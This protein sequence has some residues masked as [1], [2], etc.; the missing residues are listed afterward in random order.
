MGMTKQFY[1]FNII[2]YIKYMI[3]RHQIRTAR[4]LKGWAQSHLAKLCGLTTATIANIE[5]GK[6]NP[7][8]STLRKIETIFITHSIGFEAH[9]GVRRLET[10]IISFRGYKGFLEFMDLVDL[11]AK[12]HP[13]SEFLVAHV[14]ER[15]FM[16]WQGGGPSEKHSNAIKNANITYRILIRENDNFKP[17]TYATYAQL[18]DNAFQPVP[19]YLFG[20]NVALISFEDDDVSVMIITHPPMV[21][22]F[23]KQFEDLWLKANC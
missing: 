2:N 20:D 12:K 10:P 17:A 8:Q 13:G 23:K 21:E 9:D 1:K 16:R 6:Q 18:P 11:E 7:S 14:D 22:L 4:A 3:T 15:E 5:L 19:F